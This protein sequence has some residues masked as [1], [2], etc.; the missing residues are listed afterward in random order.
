MQD[1][2]LAD[3]PPQRRK[4]AHL[5][6]LD[7]AGRIRGQLALAGAALARAVDLDRVWRRDQRHPMTRMS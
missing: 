6:A 7:P 4:F 2:V 5:P 1:A 3:L